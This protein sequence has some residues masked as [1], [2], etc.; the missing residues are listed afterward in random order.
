MLLAPG[1]SF[2]QIT[3]FRRVFVGTLD[4]ESGVKRSSKN[5]VNSKAGTGIPWAPAFGKSVFFK[6]VSVIATLEV[7][8]GEKQ[9]W[10]KAMNFR[11]ANGIPRAPA[12]GELDFSS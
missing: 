8:L 3:V 1:P 7:E 12:F 5:E 2:L 10:I 6:G 4:V 11:V 9:S